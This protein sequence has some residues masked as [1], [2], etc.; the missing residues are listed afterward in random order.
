MNRQGAKDAKKEVKKIGNL[1]LLLGISN[2]TVDN[3]AS[4]HVI[5]G[6]ASCPPYI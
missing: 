6:W 4:L 5:V 3:L 1:I 2:S